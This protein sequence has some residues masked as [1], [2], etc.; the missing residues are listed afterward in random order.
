MEK[1][2]QK[3]FNELRKEFPVFYFDDFKYEVTSKECT[4]QYFC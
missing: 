2:N 1:R 3:K 4:V